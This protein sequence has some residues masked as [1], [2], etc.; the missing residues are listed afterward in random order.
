[1]V[2]SLQTLT[3]NLKT[4]AMIASLVTVIV[5]GFMLRIIRFK[6]KGLFLWDEAAF[7]R[8]ALMWSETLKFCIEHRKVLAGRKKKPDEPSVRQ[9]LEKYKK[10]KIADYAYYKIGHIYAILLSMK[11]FGRKDYSLAAPGPNFR[12]I[13]HTG[14]ICFSCDHIKSSGRVDC[15]SSTIF[16]WFSYSSFTIG[17]AGNQRVFLFSYDVAYGCYSE[18]NVEIHWRG[19]F[20][21]ALFFW[22][23]GG[24]GSF[25]RWACSF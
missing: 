8:N 2:N 6:K 19:I 12:H 15:R 1:M 3:N 5:L 24:D 25:F 21:D 11:I 17:R 7:Y 4:S 9:I 23:V 18:N 20:L 14:H 16:E 22:A 13:I 10:V